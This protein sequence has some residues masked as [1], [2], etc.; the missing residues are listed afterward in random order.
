MSI[1]VMRKE[2][3]HGIEKATAWFLLEM[4]MR[5]SGGFELTSCSVDGSGG[6][7]FMGRIST[8]LLP[9]A[10]CRTIIH[11]HPG[12]VDH[13][14]KNPD[15]SIKEYYASHDR[16]LHID[17]HIT[18]YIS[19]SM[20]SSD[21]EDFYML[22]DTELVSGIGSCAF[23]EIQFMKDLWTQIERDTFGVANSNLKSI[24]AVY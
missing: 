12:A 1:V 10:A 16:C 3:A 22:E 6:L 11:I 19:F 9:R 7:K 18:T 21:S 24:L 14:R 5:G 17:F 4:Y 13:F 15:M 8:T 20:I 23:Q 2:M